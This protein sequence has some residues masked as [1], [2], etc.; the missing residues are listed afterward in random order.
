MDTSWNIFI[1]KDSDGNI[2]WE[3]FYQYIAMSQN[4]A[5]QTVLKVIQLVQLDVY[6]RSH[7]VTIGTMCPPNYISWFITPMNTIVVICVS[8]NIYWLVVSTP[9]K[10]MSQLG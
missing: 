6:S 8:S 9:L 5:N 2:Q 3:Y 4:T 10:P 1:S 7:V